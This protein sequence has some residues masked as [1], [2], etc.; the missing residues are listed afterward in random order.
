LLGYAQQAFAEFGYDGATN[1]QIAE[2]SGLTMNVIYYYFGSKQ[3]LYNAA[4]EE[5]RSVSLDQLVR[6]ASKRTRF[7]DKI[8]YLVEL[9]HDVEQE[10]PWLAGF[11]VTCQDDAR[12]NPKLA[13]TVDRLFADLDA[14]CLE[15][16]EKGISQGEIAPH[17]DPRAVA[18]VLRILLLGILNLTVSLD[19]KDWSGVL[20]AFEDLLA[21][22]LITPQQLPGIE[23]GGEG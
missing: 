9:M 12:M 18:M 8:R 4:C 2:M 11:L 6:E 17:S 16:V 7:S 19:R 3:D 1:K 13:P 20:T 14:W 21:G 15:V 23:A 22:S 10:Y 5:A